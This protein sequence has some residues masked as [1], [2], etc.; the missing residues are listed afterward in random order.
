MITEKK[1]SHA[2]TT[3]AI[4]MRSGILSKVNMSA[5]PLLFHED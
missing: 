5:F 3:R 1:L 4:T 2:K